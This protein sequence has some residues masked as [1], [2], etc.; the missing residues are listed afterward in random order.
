MPRKTK[1]TQ[2][3]SPGGRIDEAALRALAGGGAFQRGQPYAR[4]GH[5]EII[6]VEPTRISARVTGSDIYH[7][8]LLGS[9]V[10]LTGSCTCL[11][12][13]DG[14]FCKH[15]VAVGLAANALSPE[16]TARAAGRLDRIR[17]HLRG[18]GVEAL[19]SLVL[20]LAE[21][22]DGLLRELEFAASVEDGDDATLF[23]AC[24]KA[25][26]STT[27]T[28][29]VEY[30]DVPAWAQEVDGV[31]DQISTLL[32][33]GR[34]ALALRLLDYFFDRM[35]AAMAEIDDSDG[36]AGGVYSRACELHLAALRAVKPDP[37]ALARKLFDRELSGVGDFFWHAFNT[38]QEVLGTEGRAEYRRLA[39]AAWQKVPVRKPRVGGTIVFDETD[40]HRRALSGIL[41]AFAEEDGDL[42]ARIALRTKDLS[43]PHEYLDLAQLCDAAGRTADALRWAEEGLWTFDTLPDRRL[44]E[45]AATLYQRAGRPDDA[46][47][48][49]WKIFDQGPTIDGYRTLKALAPE[50]SPEAAAIRDRAVAGLK[51][52]IQK[53]ARGNAWRSPADVLL[54]I[55]MLEGQLD[56]AWSLARAHRATDAIMDELCDM[57]EAS[58]PDHVLAAYAK[59]VDHLVSSGGQGN[60]TVA[61]GLIARME[62]IRKTLGRHAEHAAFVADLAVRHKAKRNFIALLQPGGNPARR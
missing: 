26:T 32:D 13:A 58:H 12:A 48:T 31:V 15:L 50:G 6:A 61:T 17:A 53:G 14:S 30:H 38:Y 39:E 59:R 36:C 7:T 49:L 9:G 10:D 33:N 51:A 40:S 41:D 42:D 24:K 2:A 34:A 54:Q 57:S 1:T 23:A 47:K 62:R 55:L 18:R 20:R 29:D 28:R 45:F 44:A 27:R 11:A 60:Y 3:A 46:A 19:V 8:E 56:D 37:I 25:I 16:E 52:M 4:D 35:D 5:V 43:A 21:H 22:D